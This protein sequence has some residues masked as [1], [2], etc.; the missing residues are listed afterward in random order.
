MERIRT[1]SSSS[2][3]VMIRP[4]AA[5]PS[6]RLSACP[7]AAAVLTASST[8]THSSLLVLHASMTSGC[9]WSCG[10][11][12][13]AW[14]AGGRQ[15]CV[16]LHALSRLFALPQLLVSAAVIVCW[17]VIDSGTS[18]QP[19]ACTFVRLLF[20]SLPDRPSLAAFTASA[21]LPPSTPRSAAVASS[22]CLVNI[23]RTLPPST[24]HSPPSVLIRET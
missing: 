5:L 11:R 22:T 1:A 10:G 14:R 4:Q 8:P 13:H 12:L 19:I 3:P 21:R 24:N 23:R 6:R 20:A 9:D 17:C 15:R 7:P 16:R 2:Q 18:Y